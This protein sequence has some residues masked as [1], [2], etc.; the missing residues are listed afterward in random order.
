MGINVFLSL[1][2]TLFYSISE[3]QSLIRIGLIADPQY[4]D[5][6]TRGSR[7]YRNSLDKLDSAVTAINREE[8][9]F[10]VMLG[11]LVDVGPKDLQPALQRLNKLKRPVYNILGNHDYVDVDDGAHLYELYNMPN[12][13]YT[14]E[15]GEWLFIMLNTNE[16]AEYATKA[17]S[18]QREAW[19][20]LNDI[21]KTAKRNNDQP[22]NGGA[23]VTQLR[24]MEK[25]L[26][27]AKSSNKKVI[28]F[29]HHPLYPE[30]G[31][32]ALNNRE[33]LALIEKYPVVKAVISGHHHPG[34]FATYK[35]IPMITLEGMI[36][37]ADQNAYGILELGPYQLDL[38]GEGRMTARKIDF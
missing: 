7:F 8:V 37:T 12:P 26:Q 38:H 18:G 17:G 22:W 14:V 36:E 33:I 21:L 34:N 11:D 23:S 13:Y 3:G 30:N 20:K 29:T 15:K 25:Q 5:R 2:F 16:L 6:D 4:A 31:L 28:V 24:W 27:K 10:T 1:L 9:D 19:K 32:E 35:G